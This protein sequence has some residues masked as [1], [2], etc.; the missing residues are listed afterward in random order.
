ML[1]FLIK[2]S[3][4]AQIDRTSK[5]TFHYSKALSS[6]EGDRFKPVYSHYSFQFLYC[7]ILSLM[8]VFGHIKRHNTIMEAILEGK[9]KD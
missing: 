8:L 1:I 2:T 4:G 5:Y 7:L 3:L 6:F 9:V